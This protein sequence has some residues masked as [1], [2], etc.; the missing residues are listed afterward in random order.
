MTR[1]LSPELRSFVAIGVACTAAYAMLYTA[2]RD[3]S[4]SATAANAISLT[5]TM[6]VNFAANRHYTF[7]ASDGPLGRQLAGYAAAYCLG[8]G[9]SS[10][11]LG[12]LLDA[13]EHPRGL[14]DTAAGVAAGLAA[15]LVRYVLMRTWVFRP[16]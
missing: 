1:V 9:V 2:L 8:L 4:L 7:R 16:A 3:A 10:L 12:A 6:G 14:A 15:T 11:L 13:L 5:A